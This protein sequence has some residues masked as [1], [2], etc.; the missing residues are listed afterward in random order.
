MKM[1]GDD[2]ATFYIYSKKYII[3]ICIQIIYPLNIYMVKVLF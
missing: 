3:Y 1:K 2:S